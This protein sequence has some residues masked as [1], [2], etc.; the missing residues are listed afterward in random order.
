MIKG[1]LK[2]YLNIRRKKSNGDISLYYISFVYMDFFGQ[3][4]LDLNET[5]IK[6]DLSPLNIYF[7]RFLI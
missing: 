2:N 7:L 5:Q 4:I 6:C 3:T 1:F